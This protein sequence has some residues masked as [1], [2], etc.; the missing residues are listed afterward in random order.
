[1][2]D[3]L[4]PDDSS[5]LAEYIAAKADADRAQSRLSKATNQLMYWMEA[6]RRKTIKTYVND[7]QTAQITYTQRTTYEINEAGLR[8]AL[9]AKTFDKYTIKKLD[10]KKLEAAMDTGEID[11]IAV[12]PYVTPK[13]GK[14]YLTFT[15]SK[16]TS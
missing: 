8:K 2:E 3:I 4:P 10:R 5:F 14:P 13:P 15:P 9:K 7:L 11:P 6:N 1:M 12:A 16:D